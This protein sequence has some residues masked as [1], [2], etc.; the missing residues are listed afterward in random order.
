[1]KRNLVVD[2][3]FTMAKRRAPVA[4][5][6]GPRQGTP[7]ADI[8]RAELAVMST[9][10][11]LLDTLPDAASRLRVLRWALARQET[12]TTADSVS[13]KPAGKVEEPAAA[14]DDLGVGDLAD[15]FKH[16]PRKGAE[17]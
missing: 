2:N 4:V 1:M 17:G 10:V 14:P 9:L 15:L 12:P 6:S 8:A 13:A 3:D 7:G 5:T 11:D 16:L